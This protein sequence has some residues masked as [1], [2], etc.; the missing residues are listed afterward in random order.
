[1]PLQPSRRDILG[2]PP[3]DV[4]DL[5]ALVRHHGSYLRQ[6]DPG[7]LGGRFVTPRPVPNR[8][9]QLVGDDG[10]DGG[11]ESVVG[12]DEDR[13]TCT[14]AGIQRFQLSYIPIDETV[15]LHWHAS[16]DS[17]GVEWKRGEHYEVDDVGL[18]TIY[19]FTRGG[20][21]W[22][23][24]G[25]VFSAQ[26]LHLDGEDE[27]EE[28]EV[29]LGA[30][31]LI[32]WAPEEIHT[33]ITLAAGQEYTIQMYGNFAIA[34][35]LPFDPFFSPC[36]DYGAPVEDYWPQAD[37]I[38]VFR[39]A[40][41][42]TAQWTGRWGVNNPVQ[43]RVNPADAWAAWPPNSPDFKYSGGYPFGDSCGVNSD[44]VVGSGGELQFRFLDALENDNNGSVTVTVW[45]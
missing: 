28:P 45:E 27:V 25:H 8:P 29:L 21:T 43:Y 36:G 4:S 33:G 16:A 17:A 24:A 34:G 10:G 26:Y 1:M 44:T 31:E 3:R 7:M 2:P 40:S 30:F 20:E 6:I 9:S 19:A 14:L 37:S 18:I 22:P 39:R 11:T 12:E 35:P 38:T 41:G 13:H 42:E 15:H 23:K 32:A 5:A